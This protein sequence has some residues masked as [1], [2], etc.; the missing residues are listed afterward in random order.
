MRHLP[1]L[2]AL[3]AGNLIALPGL[4]ESSSY[5]RAVGE[6][7]VSLG[8]TAE[9]SPLPARGAGPGR[10]TVVN[11]LL[12]RFAGSPAPLNTD[13]IEAVSAETDHTLVRGSRWL[14][15]VRADGT[16]A[17]YFDVLYADGPENTPVPRAA[18]PG[19]ANLEARARGFI[20]SHLADLVPLGPGEGLEAWHSSHQISTIERIGGERTEAVIASRIVLTR[21]RNGLP[22]LGDGS[23]IVIHIAANGVPFGF[24]LDWAPFVTGAA[25]QSP[26]SLDAIRARAALVAGSSGLDLASRIEDRF[27]CGYYDPGSLLPAPLRVLP[28][29]CLSSYRGSSPASGQTAF[30]DAIPS[31]TV[32]PVDRAWPETLLLAQ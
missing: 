7:S 4:A 13:G 20:A 16:W 1:L 18:R 23:K 12:E 8:L 14:L 25:E 17:R 22:V 32:M 9:P 26:L 5:R 2:I 21:T 31:A 3:L 27:E 19:I 6:R 24:T 30:V 11:R 29:A 28:F 10:E 15:D